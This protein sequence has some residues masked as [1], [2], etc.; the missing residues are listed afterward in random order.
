MAVNTVIFDWGGTLTPWHTVD[1]QAQWLGICSR[2]LP[3]EEAVALATQMWAA[4]AAL[5]E[6]STADH[7]S[8]TL[9]DVAS[10]AGASLPPGFWD[11]YFEAWEP[12]TFTDPEAFALLRGL[13]A[14]GLKVG[15][16][17]NTLWPRSAHEEIFARDGILE[18]I[19]GAVY[20][21]E[22]PWT[23]PHPSAFLAA[24]DAVGADDPA[25]CVFI[26]DRLFDDVF[27]AKRVGMRAVHIANS[28]VPG[29]A[30]AR[31]DAVITSLA[32]LPAHLSAW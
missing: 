6:R 31:P 29:Y 11:S 23:K 7:T 21:S 32:E 3:D 30:Q 13:R 1:H 28:P 12:H 26:G 18:L 17:S 22:I 15:V 2:H 4:E 9:E 19:D 24:M 8:A 16:L 25:T 20:S 14:A 10:R 5:W 27:G